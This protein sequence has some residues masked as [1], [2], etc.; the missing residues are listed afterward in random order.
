MAVLLLMTSPKLAEAGVLGLRSRV[1]RSSTAVLS[2]ASGRTLRQA[3]FPTLT[4]TLTPP[5]PMA[6]L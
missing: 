5:L 3:S 6:V 2:M 4:H 1:A